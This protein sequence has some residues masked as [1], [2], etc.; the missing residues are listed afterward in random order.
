VQNSDPQRFE[1]DA[2]TQP[3]HSDAGQDVFCVCPHLQLP[4]YLIAIRETVYEHRPTFQLFNFVLPVI[5]TQRLL[6]PV[7]D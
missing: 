6:R 4:T 3:S 2:G 7:N 1:Y 5:P